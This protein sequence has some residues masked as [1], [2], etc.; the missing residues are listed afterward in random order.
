VLKATTCLDVSCDMELCCYDFNV[1]NG[2]TTPVGCAILH[3]DFVP[4]L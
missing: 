4:A 3:G 1:R 2:M